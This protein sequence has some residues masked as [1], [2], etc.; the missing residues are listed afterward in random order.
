MARTSPTVENPQNAAVTLTELVTVS[1]V[2]E[3][4]PESGAK[5]R[6]VRSVVIA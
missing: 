2:A 1:E 5:M 6:S 4:D 3:L